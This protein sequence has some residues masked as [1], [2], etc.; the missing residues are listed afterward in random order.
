MYKLSVPIAVETMTQESLPLYREFLTKCGVQR[1]FLCCLGEVYRSDCMIYREPERLKGLFAFFRDLGIEVGVWVN[2]LGHGELLSHQKANEV[3]DYTPMEGVDGRT[4]PVAYCPLDE[5]FTAD[6]SAGIRRLAELGPDI[7]MLD[8]DLRFNPRFKFFQ[9]ACFCPRHLA[10]FYELVGEEVPR[11]KIEEK[12]FTG[13]PNKY[14][15]AFMDMMGKTLLDFARLLRRTVDEVDS[16]I[17]LGASITTAMWDFSGTD[18][19]ELAR[20]FAGSTRPFA[21]ISGAP[22]RDYNI[23]PI[24]ESSRQQCAWAEGSGVELMCEG[25]TYPRPRMNVP[26]RPLEL[27]DLAMLAD[28]SADG[29]L[30]YIFDYN[31]SL[32]YES[33]YAKRL[34]RN[35]PL[36]RQVAEM[37]AGK[38]AVGVQVYDQMHKF[39]AWELPEE[40]DEHTVSW[41]QAKPSK[42]A[43]ADMLARN[44]IPT[45]FSESG[46]PVLLL[47]ENAQHVS[48]DMLKNGAILDV[49]AAQILQSRGIDV[50]L[51]DAKDGAFDAEFFP[52]ENETVINIGKSG[53]VRIAC[54]ARAQVESFF[55]PGESPASYRYENSDGLRFFVMAYRFYTPGVTH[56]ANY[57]RSWCRRRQLVGAVQWLCGKPLPVVLP[58]APEACV[59]ASSN[60]KAMAVAVVNPYQDEILEPAIRL[61]K[62]YSSLKCANCTGRLEGDTVHLSTIPPFGFAAFE[63]ME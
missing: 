35:M 2:A 4:A 18:V 44:S 46:Y 47:G 50:G 41:I 21:R 13:G 29:M 7:I 37:F 57:L 26:S 43:S 40:L 27:F 24:I 15:D 38:T 9:L 55:L 19:I 45:A 8:D 32:G 61:D 6:Y 54:A 23:I 17:R 58:D 62:A 1:V 33:G 22:Y 49:T 56:S 31:Q 16:T 5:R 10:W 39:R 25:D 34:V 30:Q 12:I 14:R 36:R 42:G 28:G 51:L 52:A 48:A 53:K 20:A 63:V 59:L 11:E 3:G 60:G